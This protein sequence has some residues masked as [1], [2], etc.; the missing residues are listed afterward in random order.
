MSKAKK[1]RRMTTIIQTTGKQIKA[2]TIRQNQARIIQ[3]L[4]HVHSFRI[5]RYRSDRDCRC[6]SELRQGAR[7]LAGGGAIDRR[8]RS[9]TLFRRASAPLVRTF[10]RRSRGAGDRRRLFEERAAIGTGRGR[11]GHDWFLA[12]WAE[13]DGD[14]RCDPLLRSGAAIIGQDPPARGSHPDSMGRAPSRSPLV[15]APRPLCGR[16]VWPRFPLVPART[17]LVE[18]VAAVPVAPRPVETAQ[19][20]QWRR[21]RASRPDWRSPGSRRPRARIRP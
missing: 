17:W 6:L 20:E 14:N 7:C 18:P 1:I 11:A 4:K 12:R 15:R 16:P 2:Q 5:C 9:D 10:G 8:R 13:L 3:Q 21:T 19:H